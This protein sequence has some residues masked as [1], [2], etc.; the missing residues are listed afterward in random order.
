MLPLLLL[1]YIKPGQCVSATTF[2]RDARTISI[3]IHSY[4][5]L[6]DQLE[7]TNFKPSFVKI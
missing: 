2:S 4:P 5:F 3:N 7:L 6:V 1:N